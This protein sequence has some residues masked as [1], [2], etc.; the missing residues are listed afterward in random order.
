MIDE[1]ILDLSSGNS[2][3]VFADSTHMPGVDV[4]SGLDVLPRFLDERVEV[5]LAAGLHE[6]QV[7]AEVR[8]HLNDEVVGHL[9]NPP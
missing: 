8:I 5:V 9:H 4:L 2:G 7:A 1:E 6:V 3:Q